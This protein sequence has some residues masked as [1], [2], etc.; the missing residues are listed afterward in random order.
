MVIIPNIGEVSTE[1][2]FRLLEKTSDGAFFVGQNGVN[3]IAATGD[4]P[5]SEAMVV[6]VT[7]GRLDFGAWERI[8]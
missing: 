3:A 8:L 4:G 5:P 7:N 1:S 6:A 2:G